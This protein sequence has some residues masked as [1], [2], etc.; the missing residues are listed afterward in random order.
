MY[1]NNS[2]FLR[3]KIT[4]GCNKH[5]LLLNITRFLQQ[6]FC[7]LNTQGDTLGNKIAN[8]KLTSDN[9]VIQVVTLSVTIAKLLQQS[10]NTINGHHVVKTSGMVAEGAPSTLPP[11]SGKFSCPGNGPT[12]PSASTSMGYFRRWPCNRVSSSAV[13]LFQLSSAASFTLFTHSNV[14]GS[15]KHFSTIPRCSAHRDILYP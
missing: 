1:P 11:T 13:Y 5:V 3:L 10:N 6:Q 12:L 9:S 15:S 7:Y 14:S 8:T 2:N 4:K